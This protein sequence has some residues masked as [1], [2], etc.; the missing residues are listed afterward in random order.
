M[1][2]NKRDSLDGEVE[3]H[4]IVEYVHVQCQ[5][6]GHQVPDTFPADEASTHTCGEKSF[7]G[8]ALQDRNPLRGIQQLQSEVRI[9]STSRLLNISQPFQEDKRV[10]GPYCGTL[11]LR[12]GWVIAVTGGRL[13]ITVD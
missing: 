10:R 4:P 2:Q 13:F 11:M 12:S 7:L 8:E 1:K 9:T 6:C 5:N 3:A